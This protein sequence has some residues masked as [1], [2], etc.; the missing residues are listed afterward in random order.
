ML[1]LVTMNTFEKQCRIDY[2]MYHDVPGQI[3]LCLVD[4]T[5]S[6]GD[7]C[8]RYHLPD[9]DRRNGTALLEAC[10]DRFDATH[11]TPAV[12]GACGQT[13]ALFGSLRAENASP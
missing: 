6:R 7:H 10:T 9:P 12:I 11:G 8:C 2:S 4:E 5:I 13:V 1:P 3:C